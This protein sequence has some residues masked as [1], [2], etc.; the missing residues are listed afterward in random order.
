M[1]VSVCTCAHD[2]FMKLYRMLLEALHDDTAMVL[3]QVMSVIFENM[4]CDLCAFLCACVFV[5]V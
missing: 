1:R 5:T 4:W 2:R 3:M